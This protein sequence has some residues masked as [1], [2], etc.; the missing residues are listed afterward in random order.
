MTWRALMPILAGV[1]GAA[2]AAFLAD[3]SV[4]RRGIRV[5][6]ELTA[7]VSGRA[8]EI[9]FYVVV[10]TTAALWLAD[11]WSHAVPPASGDLSPFTPF[12]AAIATSPYTPILMISF[13][14]WTMASAYLQWRTGTL[15]DPHNS[16]IWSILALLL[17]LIGFLPVRWAALAQFVLALSGIVVY[18]VLIGRR[19]AT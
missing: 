16:A 19:R 11:V 3:R 4:K 12:A 6:D 9:A 8:R 7:F 18:L 5:K 2:L 17:L 14:A 1:A 15:T 10:A 13:I